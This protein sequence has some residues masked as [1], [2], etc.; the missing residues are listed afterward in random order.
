MIAAAGRLLLA[1]LPGLAGER[2]SQTV[3][4]AEA[5]TSAPGEGSF[6]TYFEAATDSYPYGAGDGCL[7]MDS[8]GTRIAAGV[9][10]QGLRVAVTCSAVARA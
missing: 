9:S 2:V 3:V 7:S 10:G 5:Y 6:L 4:A 1:G 8:G